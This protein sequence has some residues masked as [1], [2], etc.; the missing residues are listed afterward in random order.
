MNLSGNS[1]CCGSFNCWE[2][3]T[4]RILEENEKSRAILRLLSW[5]Q[6][7]LSCVVLC[8]VKQK[9]TEMLM[10]LQSQP[11]GQEH[12]GCCGFPFH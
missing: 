8:R 3:D 10:G 11:T 2:T 1:G 6:T 7:K 5:F 9:Y 12:P 4:F